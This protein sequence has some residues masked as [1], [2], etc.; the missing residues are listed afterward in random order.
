MLR[1]EWTWHEALP[2]EAGIKYGVNA[3]IHQGDCKKEIVK[4]VL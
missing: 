1:D 3:W 2:F 4:K